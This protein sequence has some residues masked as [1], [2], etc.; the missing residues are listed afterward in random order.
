MK[1]IDGIIY[2]VES[3]KQSLEKYE[4]EA[5]KQGHSP[6]TGF[7]DLGIEDGKYSIQRRI[8]VIRE[9]LLKIS[10]SL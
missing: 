10:K 8:R 1:S 6:Y 5:K 7:G 3:V 2:L 4:R 9:E